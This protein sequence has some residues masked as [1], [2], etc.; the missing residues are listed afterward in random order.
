[1]DYSPEVIVVEDNLGVLEA[2]VDH[3]QSEGFSVR[4]VET[5][6]ALDAA[7][8]QRPADAL[9]LDLNLP[10]EDG[11]SIAKR[12]RQSLPGIGILILSAR[13]QPRDRADGYASGADVYLPKPA[14]PHELTQALRTLC[15]RGAGRGTHK[16]CAR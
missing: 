7:L 10:F 14:S 13:V 1:M 11:I 9:V 4:G 12:V 8:A 15:S 5:G 2:L 3:L 6:Q 16:H